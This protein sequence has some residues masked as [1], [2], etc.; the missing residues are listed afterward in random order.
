MKINCLI[1]DDEPV[2]REILESYTAKI[3]QLNLVKSCQNAAEALDL[4]NTKNIDLLLLDINMPNISGLQLAKATSSKTAV[5]F[6]TAYREYAIDGFDL[7][8]V[9]Y[10]LKPI[11]FDR[12]LKAINKY[13]ELSHKNTISND[14]SNDL[15]KNDFIFI[16]SDRKMVKLNFDTI[17]YI[18]SLSDYVKIFT[19]DSMFI[20][21]ETI[22][23]IESKL[24][25]EKFLRIHR[26]YL[27]ALDKINSY[28]KE[29]LE[30]NDKALP[31]SRT[32]KTSV[33]SILD[34]I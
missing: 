27:V 5:I 20:T 1:V 22:T 15:S 8:A 4:L 32:Y 2:A 21:R 34:N 14:N 33:L 7:Q 29:H 6:T 19:K 11:S 26:S 12:F 16:R 18:E 30:I 23:N 24:P 3:P 9:D 31:L 17:L 13:F 10:L 28:T 25:H